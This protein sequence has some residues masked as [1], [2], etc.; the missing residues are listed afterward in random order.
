MWNKLSCIRKQRDGRDQQLSSHFILLEHLAQDHNSPT[1]VLAPPPLPSVLSQTDL[2][3]A[4][5]CYH[6]MRRH[7]VAS[8]PSNVATIEAR[9]TDLE[10]ESPTPSTARPA[11]LHYTT[12]NT[13]LLY[14]TTPLL[15]RFKA[16]PVADPPNS[17][18]FSSISG[19]G[20]GGGG[21]RAPITTR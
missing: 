11:H 19:G 17:S 5:H 9:T 6:Q 2:G 4:N 13:L 15:L 20:G 3:V 8:A 16:G 18:S 21:R 1:Y 12:V 7:K 14:S 10:I